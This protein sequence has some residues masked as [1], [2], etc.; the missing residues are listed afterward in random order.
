ML[1]IFLPGHVTLYLLYLINLFVFI[2]IRVPYFEAS[3][4]LVTNGEFLEFVRAGGYR[5]RKYWSEEG[6]NKKK[7]LR[8]KLIFVVVIKPD[9]DVA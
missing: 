9:S 8:E 1:A 4:F 6:M 5:N 2:C 3:K 7:G